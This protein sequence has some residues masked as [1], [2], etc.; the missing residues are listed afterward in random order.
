MTVLV[1]PVTRVVTLLV[2]VVT[3][4]VMGCDS[5]ACRRD[6]DNDPSQPASQPVCPA[7]YTGQ[8]PDMIKGSAGARSDR[9][10]TVPDR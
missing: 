3:E 10:R 7:M 9:G 2:K 8:T 1:S 4:V 5:G 6:G